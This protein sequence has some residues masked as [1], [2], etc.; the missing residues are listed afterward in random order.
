MFLKLRHKSGPQDK[1][2]KNKKP[3]KRKTEKRNCSKINK[4]ELY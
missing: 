3:K 4:K 2:K 1:P